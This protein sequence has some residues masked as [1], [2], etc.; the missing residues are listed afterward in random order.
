MHFDIAW[1]EVDTV[2]LDMDGTLTDLAFDNYFWQTLV[3]ETCRPRP[4]FA[5]GERGHAPSITPCS[6]R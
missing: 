3:P 1:Q 2:L 5:G 4:Q 6:I